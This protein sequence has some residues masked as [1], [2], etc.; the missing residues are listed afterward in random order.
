MLKL[1][2][3]IIILA[4]FEAF[5]DD[6]LLHARHLAY[7]EGLPTLQTSTDTLAIC[8]NLKYTSLSS[9]TSRVRIK[10]HVL[11]QVC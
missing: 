1:R 3:E 8:V 2:K 4:P 6:S 9:T 5:K 7:A 11:M 10:S